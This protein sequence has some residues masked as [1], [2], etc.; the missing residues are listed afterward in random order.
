MKFVRLRS[1]PRWF[2]R[3]A[4]GILVRAV[5]RIRT[6][7]PENV[8]ASGGA[9]LL[10]NHVSFADG[11]FITAACSRPVRFVMDE[12]FMASRAIRI[13]VSIF[14]TVTIRRDQPRE[15]IRTTI[16]ALKN[17][18]LVCLFPEGQL[19]RTGTLSELRRGFEL[20]A[21]K[22]GHP[23]IPLWCDGSWGSIFSFERGRFFKKRPYRNPIGMTLAFGA[24]IE[25]ESIDLEIVRQAML[26]A[27][28]AAQAKRF[29]A[30]GWG[31]RVPN[32]ESGAVEKFQT[33][34]EEFR[35]R[36]WINGYQIGQINALQR[37]LPFFVLKDS[38]T[39]LD[40]PALLLTFPE[41]FHATVIARDAFQPEPG[42]V[43][44]GGDRLRDQMTQAPV[45]D[46][47][48]F[49]DF[50]TRASAPWE[51]A[52]VRHFPCLAIDGTVVA[53]SMPDPPKPLPESEFQP[54][55]KAGS[56]GKLLP[57][58]HLLTDSSGRIRAT[59]PPHRKRGF[60]CRP[61]GSLMPRASSSGAD[62]KGWISIRKN[63]PHA[64]TCGGCHE[65]QPE[66]FKRPGGGATVRTT[67]HRL[68]KPRMA[69]A[70]R[71]WK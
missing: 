16:D 40:L 56:L 47:V 31:T 25:P 55:N 18:D 66:N 64:E 58:W 63:P 48:T 45:V 6:V 60:R 28:A 67:P 2:I 24:E 15:A 9:L 53:M 43:W 29:S 57:G 35:R 54:G 20:I 10:P 49:Y 23:L 68:T 14:D 61:A 39:L 36:M 33:G 5:Y 8:P 71:R 38:L 41:L 50:G 46:G 32:G 44:V 17:G 12:A 62:R 13:F 69:R 37:R 1:L 26:T 7:H 19:T 21:K 51:K 22:A 65:Q 42:T 59:D 70:P 30:P 3:L 4:G 52:G 34:D 11:F 27:S